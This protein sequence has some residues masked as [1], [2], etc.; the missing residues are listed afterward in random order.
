[1]KNVTVGFDFD[2]VVAYNPARIFRLPI[3]LV[4]RHVLGV[5]KTSFYVPQGE[6]AKLIWTMMFATSVFP[7]KGAALLR[8]LVA[9]GSIEA[10]LVTA[11][12]SF[13][14]GQLERWLR[15]WGMDTVFASITTNSRNEQ[16]HLFKQRIINTKRFDYFIEDNLDIVRHLAGRTKTNVFWIYNILDHAT[17]YPHKFPYLEKAL[18]ALR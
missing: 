7:A 2:G 11:R 16:P 14:E 9:R 1:M 10:H 6:L 18:K 12:F 17:P 3:A 8:Q 13:M 4:K 15:R 5:T